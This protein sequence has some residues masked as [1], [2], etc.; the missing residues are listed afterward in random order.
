M[1]SPTSST[2]P[3]SRASSWVR[4]C[5]ISAVRTG[6]ISSVLNLDAMRDS[7]QEVVAHPLQPAAHRAVEDPVANLQHHA[8]QE[9]RVGADLQD[10]LHLEL[11][12]QLRHQP[13]ALVVG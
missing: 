3:V 9:V 2:R 13:L 11:V 8:A 6:M 7:R 1:P 4:Y 5:S 12:A 10:R